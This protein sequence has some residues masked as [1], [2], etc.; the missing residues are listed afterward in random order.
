[1]NKKKVLL[2]I[3][4]TFI[5]GAHSLLSAQTINRKAVVSRHFIQSLEP[6][7][8]I[9]LGNG[10]FCFNV[11]FTGLQTTRGNTMAHWGW[12]S[13]PLP[14]G[15]TNADVPETGTLQQGRNT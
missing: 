2:G 5:L 14:E 9:P 4:L 1:M 12:H 10:E 15:F 7:L 11:D 6:N 8:E 3:F 13:F